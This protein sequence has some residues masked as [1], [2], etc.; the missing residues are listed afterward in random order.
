MF[1]ARGDEEVVVGVEIADVA[2][3][4][5]PFFVD[6]FT[7]GVRTFV[8]ALHHA[9]TFGEDFAVFRDANE[10]VGN[11]SPGAAAAILRIIGGEDRRSLRQA[12]ALVNGNADGPEKFGE[13]L[14]KGRA[15]GE[16]HAQ[17]SACSSADFFVDELVGEGP[18]GLEERAGTLGTGAPRSG[19]PGDVDGPI[20]QGA[21]DSGGFASLLHQL[22][23]NLFKE[24]RDSGDD[25]RMNFEQRLRDEVD[26]F[27]VGDR[28]AIEEVDVVEHAAVDVGERKER[29]S[30]IGG[31]LE[32]EGGAGVRYVG[33]HIIMREHHAF[34]LAGGAGGVDDGAQLAGE[35]LLG[36]HTVGGDFG[37]ARGSDQRFVAQALS[38]YVG[39]GAGVGNDDML[40][41]GQLRTAGQE[42]FQL[43][44][45]G[46]DDHARA[47]MLEDVGH[48][49]RRFVKINWDGD[50]A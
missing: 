17:F 23:V 3:V 29:Q 11:G 46:H 18:L 22:R 30:D 38:G 14:G 24:T 20:K 16:N 42:L 44:G 2:G 9:W 7:R 28:D 4:K 6:Y 33:G 13:F 43:L 12:V 21:L 8:I 39:V 26:G 19:A 40:K 31:G 15:A 10:N 41:F 47:G 27:D 45:A 37:A 34:G 1:F 32:I 49:V 25:R 5:P 36:A 50:P 35:H 48:A